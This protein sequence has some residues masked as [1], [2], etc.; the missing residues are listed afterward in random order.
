MKKSLLTLIG[1]FVAIFLCAQTIDTLTL[2]VNGAAIHSVL[3]KPL[4]NGDIALAI[5]I[6]GS[7][8]T[9]LDG[10]Q[11]M[12]KN[13]S[14]KLLSEALVSKNIATL[15]FDKFGIAK[16]ADP[17]FNESK[18]TIDRYSNDVVSLIKLMKDKGFKKI[19]II[20][21]SEGSII[22]L[23]ALQSSEAKGFISVAGAG[24]P[25]DEILRTQLKP[26]LP[27]DIYLTVDKILDSLK[28]GHQVKN[29]PQS[30]Y[31]LFR[32]SVQP[33]E[34]S[35][36]NYSPTDLISKICCPVLIVQ[37]D[38]DIQVGISDAQNL[39]NASKK[40]KLV[41]IKNMNHVLK[42]INGDLQENYSSYTNPDL[43][44]NQEL[45]KEITDF[46]LLNSK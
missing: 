19:F 32:P 29:I 37:G 23:I 12:M 22:G 28:N 1:C 35:W 11:L 10:N 26:Q 42:T 6:A 25:A 46:I 8:P 24:V 27:P 33:Y 21:H 4:I 44:V 34:I 30:L 9:D 15:R 40:G 3:T 20:G 39:A 41:I 17:N 2:N 43:P 45:S 38:K 18:L 5:F 16:S 13:N 7:G 36:F 14:L 31:A